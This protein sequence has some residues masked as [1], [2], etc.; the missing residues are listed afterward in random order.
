MCRIAGFEPQVAFRTD[1]Y[2]SIQGLVAVGAGIGVVPRLSLTPRR[3][4]VV[5]VPMA[6]PVFS[7]RIAVLEAQPASRASTV[8]DLLDVLRAT[9]DS[10]RRA[11][12]ESGSKRCLGQPIRKPC[13][14]CLFPSKYH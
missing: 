11:A 6:A 4:D 2:Q 5:A 3:T 9:A 14:S 12:A 7:R 8:D 13:L 10:L 1:N